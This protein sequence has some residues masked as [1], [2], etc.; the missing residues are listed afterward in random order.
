MHE[1]HLLLFSTT[2]CLSFILF[3][4]LQ[5]MREPLLEEPPGWEAESIVC[6]ALARSP[7]K[8]VMGTAERA[9]EVFKALPVRACSSHQVLHLSDRLAVI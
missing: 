5:I 7:V 1:R 3:E 4:G 8:T 6:E 2:S 9:C